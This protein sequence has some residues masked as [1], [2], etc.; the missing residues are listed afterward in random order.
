MRRRSFIRATGAAV[1]LAAFDPTEAWARAWAVTAEVVRAHLKPRPR[2]TVSEWADKH[3]VLP[4]T[5]A[6][7]GRWRTARTPYLRAI[8][9]A[10][11]D[12]TVER[13]VFKKPSQVGGSEV[14]LNALGYFIDQDPAPILF[15]QISVGEAK[16]FS[17][18]RIATMIEDTDV[19]RGK[20]S[21]SKSRDSENTISSKRFAGGHLGI[22]GANAPSGL[23]SRPR[24]VRLYD[25]IDGYPQSAGEEGDPIELGE[26]RGTTFWNSISGLISTPTVEGLSRIQAALDDCDEVYGYFVPCSHCDHMQQLKWPN[27]RWDKGLVDGRKVHH[28]ETAAYV[29]ESCG[30]TVADRYRR[31]MIR[32]V[33]EG[34]SAEW[35][36]V[37]TN[38][39]STGGRSG[40]WVGFEMNA[41]YSPWVSWP[42]LADEWLKAQGRPLELQV[43][44]NTRLGETWDEST[45]SLDPDS[46]VAR[47]EEYAADPLPAGVLVIT[48]GVDVQ[49]DRLEA[50]IVGWGVGEESWSLEYLRIPGDPTGEEIWKLLDQALQ[51]TYA[52]PSGVRLPVASACIDSRYLTQTVLN[53]C[54][55]RQGAR[56]WPVHG[57]EGE[58]RP[59]I[60]RPSMKNRMKV[61]RYPIGVDTAKTVLYHRLATE[62]PKDWKEGDPIPGYCHFPLRHPYDQEHFRQL[63]SEKRVIRESRATRQ[64]KAVWVRLPGRRNEQLDIRNYA[65][66]GL[67]GLIA[68]GLRLEA[69]AVAMRERSEAEPAPE[70]PTRRR[71][72]WVRGD[73]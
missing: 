59:I 5:S 15:V 37:R 12:P 62:L 26:K 17:K 10:F 63:I 65:T 54:K 19:L 70:Q 24:R 9:D 29:C 23:R 61:P 7:P 16:N 45:S 51:Q 64:R 69:L 25:E 48:A 2:I 53:Y 33:A 22:V 44:I 34:G 27:V 49:A 20:V 57:V 50:E 6:E 43:F 13:V 47:R 3:R 39:T 55:P 58:G 40:R 46:V 30:A 11:S 71:S 60:D 14:I 1:A 36:V 18:E 8:M 28:P 56:I 52:H 67:E 21:E 35:R 73:R 68:A 41:L 72:G 38:E 66:G 32:T 31:R 42:A 4:D